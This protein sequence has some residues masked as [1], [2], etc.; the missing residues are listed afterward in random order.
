MPRRVFVV[1]AELSGDL[2]AAALARALQVMDEEIVLEGIGGQ[3]M[4]NAGVVVHHESVSRAAMTWRA[5]FRAL[6]VLR[7]LKWARRYFAANKP[8]LLVCIDSFAMNRHFAKLAKGMGIPVLYYVPPQLWASRPGRIEQL[9]AVVDKVASI[10]PF[11]EEY[12]RSRGVDARFVGHPLLEEIQPGPYVEDGAVVGFEK[13]PP[14]VGLLAGSRKGEVGNNFPGMLEVT[15]RIREA[16]PGAKFLAPTTHVTDP[17]VTKLAAGFPDIE[18]RVGAIDWMTP[19]CDFC[20]VKSGTGTLQVA[21]H[22]VPMIIMYRANWLAWHG[23][24]RWIVKTRTFGLI[25]L[26]AGRGEHLEQKGEHVVPEFVP[27]FGDSRPIAEMALD[28][29]RN[30]EK[31]AGQRRELK[32]VVSG[33]RKAGPNDEGASWNVARMAVEMM[34][35]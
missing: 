21:A 31:L 22:G 30:P 7:L 2:H 25:N 14:V 10:V 5:A 8:D 23:I 20:L 15:A 34:G 17:I 13:R 33:L 18:V 11:E 29:L 24:A 12:L 32:R 16:F 19:R 6:E 3:S 9:R 28:Y 4:R 35:G 27:W 1:V 26:L